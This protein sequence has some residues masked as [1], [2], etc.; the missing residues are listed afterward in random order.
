MYRGALLQ[1]QR[2]GAPGRSITGTDLFY[3]M[4]NKSVPFF[5]YVLCPPAPSHIAIIINIKLPFIYQRRS[6][7]GTLCLQISF[8]I[9]SFYSIGGVFLDLW[10]IERPPVL[11]S[12]KIFFH[13]KGF[14]FIL[15]DN[16]GWENENQ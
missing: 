8:I 16:N 3:L 2:A 4:E 6:R 12:I 11:K 13:K 10:E 9:I 1:W 5:I 14:L 15:R 7:G